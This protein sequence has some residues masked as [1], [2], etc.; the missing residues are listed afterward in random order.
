MNQ[1]P[2]TEMLIAF[3]ERLIANPYPSRSNFLGHFIT[4]EL[5]KQFP[6]QFEKIASR[7]F[8]RNS[9]NL[10]LESNY[11]KAFNLDNKQAELLY[12]ILNFS[13][14]YQKDDLTDVT[15][16]Q[17]AHAI[18]DFCVTIQSGESSKI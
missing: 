6:E 1:Q 7:V 4:D 18:F 2:K 3:A 14:F 16:E 13:K 11:D 9:D 12:K 8:I 15:K 17:I 5:T 10:R